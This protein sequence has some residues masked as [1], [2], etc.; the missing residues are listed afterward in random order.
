MFAQ[1]PPATR[2]LLIANVAVFLL[3]YLT[4][5]E[6]IGLFALEPLGPDFHLWQLVTYAFLHGGLAHIF[7]NMFALYMFGGALEQFWGGR[8]FLVFYFV[9]VVA[10]GLT[11]LLTTHLA[12]LDEAT[13]GASGGIFGLLFAY[14]FYFPRQKLL[15]LFLPIPVPA[16]LFVTL[17]ILLEFSLGVTGTESGVAHFAHLGGVLGGALLVLYW[18]MQGRASRPRW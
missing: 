6:F 14:A 10:A 12:G 17:Y 5:N 9:C 11:Q 8:R 3:Q 15:L 2:G 18:R 16:W 7:F 13:I 1:L 4:H